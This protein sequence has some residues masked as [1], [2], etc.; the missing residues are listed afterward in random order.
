M[1]WTPL[2]FPQTWDELHAGVL[3]W[4]DKAWGPDWHCPHCGNGRWII[5]E[6]AILDSARRWPIAEGSSFGVYPAIPVACSRCRDMSL[7]HAFSIF[8]R[9]ADQ[10]P[11]VQAPEES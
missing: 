9:P 6:A 5:A 3:A 4:L 8:E 1:D 10:V 7:I 11:K 2:P